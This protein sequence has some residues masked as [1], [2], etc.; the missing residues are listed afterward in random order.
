M[1]FFREPFENDGHGAKCKIKALQ[2][3]FVIIF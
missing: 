1:T 2:N 3:P